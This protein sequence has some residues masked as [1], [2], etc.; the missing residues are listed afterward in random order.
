MSKQSTFNPR[1]LILA[2]T[3]MFLL[4]LPIA[5]ALRFEC[6]ISGGVAICE[7]PHVKEIWERVRSK[8]TM[9]GT[10]YTIEDNGTVF[11][12]LL[13]D[14]QPVNDGSCLLN[15]YYPDKTVLFSDVAMTYLNDSNGL[16]Y[17]DFVV[18]DEL[19]VYMLD[20]FC[21]WRIVEF[22]Y[23]VSNFTLYNGSEFSGTYVDTF[24]DDDV[25][26][27]V[28]EALPRL[29]FEYV[30]TVPTYPYL[31]KEL[32]FIWN[33]RWSDTDENVQIY[34]YNYNT[35][36]W[37]L[38]PNVITYSA[39]DMDVTNAVLDGGEYIQNNTVRTLF[40]D[41]IKNDTVRTGRLRND[42]FHLT[43]K[44]QCGEAINWIRG[45]GELHVSK[46]P[47]TTALYSDLP[48]DTLI[49]NH[50]YCLDNTTLRTEI[51]RQ[52]CLDVHCVNTSSIDDYV[53]PYGC[54]ETRNECVMDPVV[55]ILI[56]IFI[57]CF[58][59]VLIWVYFKKFRG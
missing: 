9:Y 15:V 54:D 38:L 53:C 57:I 2:M 59:I 11:L 46:I 17:Y 23:N 30:F 39:V 21:Y 36:T 16:Y 18:P 49:S 37:D 45:G 3:I 47:F 50:R 14:G 32:D 43:V 12:Q 34:V 35:S 24:V 13:E 7:L 33:G 40:S 20:S 25:Y 8:I 31:V 58:I 48:E 56:V 44:C 42:M 10:E 22:Q 41:T 5:N 26:H 27:I 55:R 4:V 52:R 1:R 6:T 51:I 19:G 29:E 28:D